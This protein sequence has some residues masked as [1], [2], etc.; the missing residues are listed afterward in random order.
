MVELVAEGFNEK[1]GVLHLSYTNNIEDMEFA[2]DL[3][4]ERFPNSKIEI[5]TLPATIVAHTGLQTIAI[6]YINY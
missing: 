1:A 3:L 6:G 5:Y 4:K 2:K